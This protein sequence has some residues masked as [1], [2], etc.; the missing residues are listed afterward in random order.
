MVFGLALVMALSSCGGG[1]EETKKPANSESKHHVHEGG[2]K[3]LLADLCCQRGP[4]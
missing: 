3:R 4:L 2:I 1:S